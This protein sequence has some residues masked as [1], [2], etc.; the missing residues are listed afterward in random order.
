MSGTS[1]DGIDAAL[2]SFGDASVEIHATHSQPYPQELKDALL[3]AIREPLDVALDTSGELDR[4]VGECFRDAALTVIDNSGVSR[5]EVVATGSHG[6]TLRHQP[7]A[8]EPFSLQIGN[9]QLI[10]AGTR[11]TTVANFRQADIAA[12][13][14]GAPLVPPFHQWLFGSGDNG[15]VIVNIGGIA[16]ISVLLAGGADVL[17]FDTGPGNGLMDAWI[18]R[19]Q[20][21]PYD[22]EGAWAASGSVVESLL[23]EFQSDP[24]FKLRTPK[25]TGFEYFNPKWLRSFDVDR[26]A[27]AD[28]QAT[29][30]ELSATTIATAINE[31]A[32]DSGE[33]FVC[34]GGVHNTEL[35]RRLDRHLPAATVSSTRSV[36]L[37]PGWVEAVAFA[38]LAMRTMQ[39]QTGNL[40]SVTGASHKVVLGDI[41][42][43]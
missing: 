32:G 4:R 15:R 29:L 39:G 28:V 12:G 19:H 8:D 6:Q 37:D 2:V 20:G 42:S 18:S 16:N 38:W 25:S 13:G 7:N 26:C 9:A 5:Q 23:A 34:G 41:H 24:Y 22:A 35:M 17:G 1:M 11:I 21:K 30:C 31:S 36:G 3:V 33:V 10:A 14:Q 27:A 43:P 40:P